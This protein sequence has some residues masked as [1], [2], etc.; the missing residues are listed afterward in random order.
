MRK[1]LRIACAAAAL[2]VGLCTAAEAACTISPAPP[3]TPT[4]PCTWRSQQ[5]LN[6]IGVNVHSTFNGTSYQGNTSNLIS[7][8]QYL[9]IGGGV[10]DNM[11]Q[12]SPALS[13]TQFANPMAI[14]AAG[15][16]ILELVPP[17]VA[18]PT[19]T[20]YA[21]DMDFVRSVM[22]YFYA[23]YPS[24]IIGVE[25][26]N[27]PNPTAS[28]PY[29]M[30][31]HGA[32][33]AQAIAMYQA[34]LYNAIKTDPLLTGLP[35]WRFSI[36]APPYNATADEQVYSINAS[37]TKAFDVAVEHDYASYVQPEVSMRAEIYSALDN[38]YSG[39]AFSA[40]PYAGILQSK[41]FAIT[42]T[43]QTA[44]PTPGNQ[45]LQIVD[46]AA[47]TPLVLSTLLD[48]LYHGSSRTFL[49]ELADDSADAGVTNGQKHFG[50]FDSTWTAK[51]LAVALHNLTGVLADAGGTALT[52]TPGTATFSVAQFPIAGTGG[53]AASG[54]VLPTQS[55]NGT[56]KVL[57]WYEPM[58]LNTT[59]WVDNTIAPVSVTFNVSGHSCASA[60][61]FDPVAN[62]TT[63]LGSGTSLSLSLPEN[64]VVVSCP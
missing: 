39:G 21:D 63:S 26:Q 42:E 7:S 1:F 6:A 33:G 36:H 62:T 56:Y 2:A 34:E 37:I 31:F 54:W 15:I 51:P 40:G 24:L 61:M 9:G 4:T 13:P 46:Y 20:P 17:S 64:P 32:A 3:Y 30:L 8:Y 58:I 28:S 38:G 35:V 11:P 29:A 43:G 19:G 14:L 57:V 44:A 16:P 53:A 60:T 41:P 55:S 50:L 52:F 45:S 27:E 18:I 12:Y 49:Y 48:T 59:T 22:E 5:L 47:Q 23:A 25:G 10:R